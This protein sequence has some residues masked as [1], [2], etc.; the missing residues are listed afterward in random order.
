MRLKFLRGVVDPIWNSSTVVAGRGVNFS[1]FQGFPHVAVRIEIRLEK[2]TLFRFLVAAHLKTFT[3]RRSGTVPK[4]SIRRTVQF[5]TYTK[6][7]FYEKNIVHK[8]CSDHNSCLRKKM[9]L[10]IFRLYRYTTLN[11]TLKTHK[12]AGSSFTQTDNTFPQ[13]IKES[14][15]NLKFF[16][17]SFFKYKN[18]KRKHNEHASKN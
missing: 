6:R 9:S 11:R 2:A 5:K 1:S 3:I 13:P 14:Q 16:F 10:G 15:S 12:S 4:S 7:S 17:F 18:L 8:L